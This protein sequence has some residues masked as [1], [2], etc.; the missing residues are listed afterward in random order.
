ME[1][2]VSQVK[3]SPFPPFPIVNFAKLAIEKSLTELDSY[4]SSAQLISKVFQLRK[5]DPIVAIL[6]VTEMNN[7]RPQILGFLSAPS[8]TAQ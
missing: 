1:E 4:E 8:L 7:K 3:Y 6:T 2:P 5:R